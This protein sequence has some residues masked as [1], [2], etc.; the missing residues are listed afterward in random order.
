M[1]NVCEKCGDEIALV[2]KLSETHVVKNINIEGNDQ[3][4]ISYLHFIDNN[5]LPVLSP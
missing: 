1:A 5:S 4:N 2:N 3:Q